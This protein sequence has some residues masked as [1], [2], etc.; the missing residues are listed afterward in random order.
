MNEG[1]PR[2]GV[3]CFISQDILQYVTDV[4]RSFD[5]HIVILL[6]GGHRIFG[7]YIPPIDSL[8]YSDEY[9][10]AVPCFLSPTHNDCVFIGGGDM[11]SRVG[12]MLASVDI[13][14]SYRDNIDTV[15]NENGKILKRICKNTSSMVLN[16]LNFNS[17]IFD[18]DFTFEK[19]DKRSQND[20][21]LT[22]ISGLQKVEAFD[23]HNVSFNFSD[24]KP[25]S[26]SVEIPILT[27]VSSSIVA[28][29]IL[30]NSWDVS[31]RRAKKIS[32]EFVDWNAYCLLAELKIE[33]LNN[34]LIASDDFTSDGT[35]QNIV[36]EME[37]GLYNAARFCQKNMIGTVQATE[38]IYENRSVEEI[39][40]NLSRKEHKK[41]NDILKSK[42]C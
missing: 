1:K 33:N 17:K 27:G 20:F 10:N 25:I 13:G 15:V 40:A 24:H 34:K 3:S 21:C 5:N 28:E 38:L 12:K 36:E 29:D 4:D 41:W 35:F 22:N 37:C 16:N 8:Y 30:S 23:I 9:Y 26:V 11:N 14:A 7:S 19:G 31:P 32:P 2:W 39:D 6:K 18:G 42:D